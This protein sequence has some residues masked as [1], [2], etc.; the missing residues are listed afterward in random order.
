MID[1]HQER[2]LERLLYSELAET[3]AKLSWE[4]EMVCLS[5]VEMRAMKSRLRMSEAL[6]VKCSSLRWMLRY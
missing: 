2:L 4:K 3:E 5:K 1:L 6:M